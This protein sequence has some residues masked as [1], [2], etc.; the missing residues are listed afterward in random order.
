M[1]YSHPE[2]RGEDPLSPRKRPR[3][4]RSAATVEV[5]LDGAARILECEGLERF[6][7]NAVAAVAGVSVGS[8]YQYF[9][10]KDALM[11]ALVRRDATRFA[12]EVA[13]AV[14]ERPGEDWR[15]AVSRL[16]AAAVGH[17]LDL[18]NLARILDF[19]EGRL[20]LDAETAVAEQA[21]LDAIV[22]V[23]RRGEGVMVG[24]DLTEAA[25]DLLHLTRALVDAEGRERA[26]DRD[27]LSRR[28]RRAV[29]GYLT[30][31]AAAESAA[32]NLNPT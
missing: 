12:A 13:E 27:G 7:T 10:G 17:Q 2:G 1:A 21:M 26:P 19:E 28:L 8:L 32:S 31:E 14:A 15:E 24:L 9:P 22:G 5:I 23:L 4:K 20:P 11:A 3:Q 29:F 16:I 30:F 6:N 18:P 25:A